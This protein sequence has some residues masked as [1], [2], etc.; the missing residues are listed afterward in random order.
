MADVDFPGRLVAL[1]G[2]QEEGNALTGPGDAADYWNLKR[3]TQVKHDIL[4]DYLKR[5]ASILSGR[6][7]GASVGVR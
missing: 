2:V 4:S 5:W 7:A 1:G 3:N 6:D